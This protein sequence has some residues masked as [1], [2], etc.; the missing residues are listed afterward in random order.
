MRMMPL[1][2]FDFPEILVSSR[3]FA[4]QPP[5]VVHNGTGRVRKTPPFEQSISKNDHFTKTGSGQT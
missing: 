1:C 2:V 4:V 5:Y 3:R